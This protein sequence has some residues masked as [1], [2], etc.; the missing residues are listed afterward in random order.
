M[1]I[2]VIIGL[3]AFVRDLTQGSV[4]PDSMPITIY[5]AWLGL[6]LLVGLVL[7]RFNLLRAA[8]FLSRWGIWPALLLALLNF[9][10]VRSLHWAFLQWPGFLIWFVPLAVLSLVLGARE[11]RREN[12]GR[13]QHED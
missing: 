7:G 10:S 13:V 6:V 1:A 2:G 3:A 8:E 4:K 11:M 12:T 5:I 9:E